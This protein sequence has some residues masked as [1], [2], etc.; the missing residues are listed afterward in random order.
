MQENYNVNNIYEWN[1]DDC[2]EYNIMSKLQQMKMVAIAYRTA[3]NCLDQLITHVLIARFTG[4]LKGWWDSHHLS[5]KDKKNIFQS[6][7]VDSLG[8]SILKDG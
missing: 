5:E 1:T 2:S 8:E 4:Q 6:V 3:H 7:R